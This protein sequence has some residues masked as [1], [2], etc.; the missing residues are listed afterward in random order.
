M[1][2]ALYLLLDEYVYIGYILGQTLDGQSLDRTN[3]TTRTN[4]TIF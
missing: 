3:P 4:E 2:V 1:V